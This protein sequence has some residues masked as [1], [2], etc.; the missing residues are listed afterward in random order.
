[1]MFWKSDGAA[2]QSRVDRLHPSRPLLFLGPFCISKPATTT[3]WH[4]PS[5][6]LAPQDGLMG[7]GTGAATS[8]GGLWSDFLHCIHLGLRVGL[9]TVRQ[10][11]FSTIG[12]GKGSRVGSGGGVSSNKPSTGGGQ[13]G[14]VSG[15]LRCFSVSRTRLVSCRLHMVNV[16]GGMV[17]RRW[18]N[19][20]DNAGW[21]RPSPG[22]APSEFVAFAQGEMR[23]ARAIQTKQEA[24]VGRRYS[25]APMRPAI[26]HVGNRRASLS[27]IP[28]GSIQRVC[29][30]RL[31][32]R[33]P[34]ALG[35][36]H[37]RARC[38][39]SAGDAPARFV[40]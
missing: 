1:M 15:L 18:R 38:G 28:P 30:P 5:F 8:G 21:R 29:L 19:Q 27:A 36:R 14:L 26:L 12:G 6:V 2:Y 33:F 4:P 7:G 16:S 39:L 35:L 9:I 17:E 13:P 24:S 31:P 34:G 23:L 32:P 20:P 3:V 11:Q 22:R 25:H 10:W 40:S 37:Q